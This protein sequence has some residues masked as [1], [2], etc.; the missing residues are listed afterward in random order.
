MTP[1]VSLLLSP[2]AVLGLKRAVEEGDVGNG[3]NDRVDAGPVTP[4]LG[5]SCARQGGC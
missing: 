1:I 3:G 5:H 2:L 4:D